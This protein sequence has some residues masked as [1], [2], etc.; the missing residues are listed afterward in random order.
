MCVGLKIYKY[1][2]QFGH[3]ENIQAYIKKSEFKNY[4]DSATSGKPE[5]KIAF[6]VVK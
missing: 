3:K 2:I 6:C 5:V 4:S 1:S